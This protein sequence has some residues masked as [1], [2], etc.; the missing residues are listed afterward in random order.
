MSDERRIINTSAVRRP[1]RYR[2]GLISADYNDS[3]EEIVNDIKELGNTVNSLS[4]RLTRS[5]LILNNEAAHLRRQ[6]NALREQQDYTERAAARFNTV[7]HRF[8]DFSNTE[9]ISFPNGLD[10]TSSAMLA[11]EYGEITLPANS[12][13]NKFYSTSLSTGKIVT[14]TISVRVSGTFDKGEGAGLVNYEKGGKVY[15]GKPEYAFNGVNDLYWVRKVEFP[16]DSRVDEVECEL[17]VTV[18]EGSSSNSNLIE[19][20]PFPNG[21]VDIIELSTASDLGNNFIRVSSFEPTDNLVARRYHFPATVVDQIKIRMRQR[22]WVEENGKKVFY[23]GLQELALKLVD[24][25][26]QYT[27]GASFGTNNSFI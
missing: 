4:S 9:G 13:E 5:I 12:I 15:E 1:A 23:Y 2:G 24:Y 22:N 8:I 7:A 26:K 14:P 17:T 18:P 3:Q 6:V 20:I 10:D 27:A 19:V 11:A 16:I 21:A 25:D